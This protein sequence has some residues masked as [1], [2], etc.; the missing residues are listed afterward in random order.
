MG[1]PGAQAP[2]LCAPDRFCHHR[3]T[4]S[5]LTV[6]D[7]TQLAEATAA[8]RRRGGGTAAT[9]ASASASAAPRTAAALLRILHR[10][11]GTTRGD[12]HR[13]LDLPA[14]RA[15]SDLHARLSAAFRPPAP[16]A[17]AKNPHFWLSSIDIQRVMEQYERRNRDFYFAGVHPLDFASPVGGETRPGPNGGPNGGPIGGPSNGRATPNASIG[18]NALTAPRPQRCISQAM[19]DLDVA[20]LGRDGRRQVGTVINMDRHDS[21]GSHW[22]AC[23]AGLDP[24]RL[25]YGVYYYDSVALPPPREI[26]DFMQRHVAAQVARLSVAHR[27]AYDA[28]NGRPFEVRHNT[29]RR[30][31]KNTECGIFS[32]IFL[33]NCMQ[34]T[35]TFDQICSGI[36]GDADMNALRRVLFRLPPS[37]APS[38]AKPAGRRPKPRARARARARTPKR[39]TSPPPKK[40]APRRAA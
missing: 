23:Y 4:G 30:Q 37:V 21:A 18:P 24:T 32:V 1:P 6:E 33:L 22:V 35:R 11:F 8:P 40:R 31:F 15:L 14:V 16:A 25:L 27:A 17:W 7:L 5:C 38:P 2:S 34:G 10:R 36:G 12:E 20:R 19:C 13:W 29:V 39:S 26:S 9:V 28:P 3:Q